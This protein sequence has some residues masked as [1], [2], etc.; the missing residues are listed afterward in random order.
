MAVFCEYAK[1]GREYD[2]WDERN[3]MWLSY[4]IKEELMSLPCL[5]HFI[6]K[7]NNDHDQAFTSILT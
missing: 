7:K 4:I 2:P 5:K 6:V 1:V 3:I